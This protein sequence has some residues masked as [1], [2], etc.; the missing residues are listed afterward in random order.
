MDLWLAHQF[1]SRDDLHIVKVSLLDAGL[2]RYFRI[3][4]YITVT[5]TLSSLRSSISDDVT[6]VQFIDR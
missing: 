5:S 1:R 2:L 4:R 3:L 6:I